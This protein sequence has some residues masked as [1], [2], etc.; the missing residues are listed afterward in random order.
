VKRSHWL[1]ETTNVGY[2]EGVITAELRFG[3]VGFYE[4]YRV[5]KRLG[6]EFAGAARERMRAVQS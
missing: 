5:P 1:G 4:T 6:R 3:G 2:D